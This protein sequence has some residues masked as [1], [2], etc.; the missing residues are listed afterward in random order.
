MLRPLNRIRATLNSSFFK[1]LLLVLCCAPAVQARAAAPVSVEVSVHSFSRKSKP[2]VLPGNLWLSSRKTGRTQNKA[3]LLVCRPGQSRSER[4]ELA[5]QL[6]QAGFTVLDVDSR[7]SVKMPERSI[8]E[9]VQSGVAF[10]RTDSRVR[11]QRIVLVGVGAAA[12]GVARYAAASNQMSLLIDALVLSKPEKEF[13][14]LLLQ[15]ALQSLGGIR[16][17]LIG[18]PVKG[19]SACPGKCRDLEPSNDD[20]KQIADFALGAH[21]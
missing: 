12:P 1:T 6:E 17:L 11:A 18:S 3:V 21:G 14:H 9:D 4:N 7:N 20:A 19:A 15:E 16:T 10:L 2:G 13:H 5:E 8:V